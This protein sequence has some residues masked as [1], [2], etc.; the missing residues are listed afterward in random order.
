MAMTNAERQRLWRQ[1]HPDKRRAQRAAERAA[2]R[3][4]RDAKRA[5][6]AAE[7]VRLNPWIGGLVDLK[8]LA[9]RPASRGRQTG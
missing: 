6:H 9:P 7:M 5:E 1:R 8:S 2:A 3:A 4:K